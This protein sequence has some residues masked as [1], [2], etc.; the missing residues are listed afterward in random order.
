[1]TMDTT[2]LLRNI[3]AS[4]RYRGGFPDVFKR[5]YFVYS[6]RLPRFIR[7]QEL[8]IAFRYPEP[9]GCVHLLLRTN[10]GSD[11]FIH[12]EVFE[13][14]YYQLGLKSAPHTILDLGANT[15]LTAVYFNRCFPDAEL[16]CVEPMPGNVAALRRNLELNRVK[17]TVFSGAIHSNDGN[18]AMEIASRDYGHRVLNP[19]KTVTNRVDVPA[20]AVPTLLALLGWDRIGL[21][22]IDIEGH[23]RVLLSENESWLNRVD[24]ICIECHEG[25]DQRDLRKLAQKF[26]FREPQQLPGVW[27][28]RRERTSTLSYLGARQVNEKY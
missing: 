5:I 1:M 7:K 15:G 28:L 23:E 3:E 2:W 8:V 9:V 21:L 17:A 26:G 24:A 20:F 27:L 12:S 13:H 6:G 16:A 19:E 25:F 14:T 4:W 10:A 22:K 18:I 11:A